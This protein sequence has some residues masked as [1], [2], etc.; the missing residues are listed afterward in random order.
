M[1]VGCITAFAWERYGERWADLLRAVDAEVVL[2][3]RAAVL[4]EAERLDPGD[5][6]VAWLA[7]A[8]LRALSGVDLVI[9]PALLPNTAS[10]PGSA[11]DP[12]VVDLVTMLADAEPG[13]PQ[14]IAVPAATGPAVEA[15]VIPVLTRVQRDAGRVRRAWDRYR[16]AALRPWRPNAA[17]GTA[18]DA[19][20]VALAASPW[21]CGTGLAAALTRPGEVMVGQHQVDP[22]ALRAEGWRWRGDINDADAETLGAVRRYARRGDVAGVRLVID[23]ASASQAWLQRRAGEIAGERLETVMLD[24][25]LAPEALID[26][27]L[28]VDPSEPA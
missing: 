2:P 25:A 6:V 5:G 28:P 22:E 18:R 17:A 3:S 16:V 27:L 26:A 4:A 19:R 23:R 11:Q 14:L 9:V 13:A 21:W 20:H 1:R 10:G 8:S 15:A 12:W 7:R 24:E